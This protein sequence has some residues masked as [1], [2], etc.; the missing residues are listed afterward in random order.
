MA[1]T[2]Q[3][4]RKTCPRMSV[5]S[6]GAYSTR[7]HAPTPNVPAAN[8]YVNKAIESTEDGRDDSPLDI[9]D[10]DSL[11]SM[12]S[13]SRSTATT[14]AH[15]SSTDSMVAVEVG[16]GD[17][18]QTFHVHAAQLCKSSEYLKTK[19]KPEWSKGKATVDLSYQDP[20]AFNIYVN[21]LYTGQILSTNAKKSNTSEEW[22]GLARAFTL[23]EE[24]ID[25]DF[26]NA[27]MSA[28]STT[29][30]GAQVTDFLDR[31]GEMVTVIYEGSVEGSP[32]RNFLVDRGQSLERTQLSKLRGELHADYTFDLALARAKVDTLV[33]GSKKHKRQPISTVKEGLCDYH[34]HGD[35]KGC[36]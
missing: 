4:A 8:D 25:Q 31:L 1:R 6:T 10:I 21:W 3:T 36:L 5:A 32:A 13:E 34:E 17:E 18:A 7:S 11:D 24:L 33:K 16:T 26:K 2:M 22:L 9:I 28:L 20:G 23:G 19:A 30:S 15:Q 35:G 14:K 12:S 27:I 29:A